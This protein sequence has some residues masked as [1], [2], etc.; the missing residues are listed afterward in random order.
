MDFEV[1]TGRL[2]LR[3]WL[4]SDRAPFAVLNADAEVMRF[5]PAP[6]DRAQ[7]DG[8]AARADALFDTHGYGLWALER[9]DTGEFI[10][11]TGLA[12]LPEGIPGAGG[13]E[14]GWR[15]APTAWGH[16][17]AT[18]AAMAALRF[19][20]DTVGLAEVNSITAVV[21]IRSRKVMER[22]GMRPAG[23]FDHPRVAPDSA[24]RRHVRYRL[25]AVGKP[26]ETALTDP[27]GGRDGA[28]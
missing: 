24:L 16:G 10:G 23:E 17:F 5:F 2:L 27:S 22:L 12:P 3:R 8:L 13:V 19:G 28:N 7:S 14:V 15:L 1:R 20:F 11:F 6:L 18:E 21:N 26:A 25:P 4:D 9:L